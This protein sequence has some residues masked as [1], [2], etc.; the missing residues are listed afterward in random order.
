MRSRLWIVC[1]LAAVHGLFFIWYQQPDWASQWSDQGGYRR[2]G[3][4]L[5][6]TGKF[7]RYPDE[8]RFVPEVIRTPVYPAF[9][10]V[11]YRLFGE[12]QLAVTLAQTGLFV[13][14]CV[15]VYRTAVLVAWQR[16]ALV[17]A[18]ATALF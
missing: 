5:S 9:V 14:I 1:L 8:P 3:L 4:V 16:T 17:A 13:L 10:A 12:S 18:T 7:T 15:L 2:L 11:V 6:Q